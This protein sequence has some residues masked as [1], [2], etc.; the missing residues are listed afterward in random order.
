MLSRG[1]PADAVKNN[2]TSAGPKVLGNDNGSG[3]SGNENS[4]HLKKY[5]HLI[6]S[7]YAENKYA[8]ENDYIPCDRNIPRENEYQVQI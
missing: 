2:R 5:A 1:F 6:E 3:A 7:A 8:P 4:H